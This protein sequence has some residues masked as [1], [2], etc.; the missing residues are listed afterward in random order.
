VYSV[1]T[2]AIGGYMYA[3]AAQGTS[4]RYYNLGSAANTAPVTAASTTGTVGSLSDMRDVQ[5]VGTYAYVAD[6]AAGL[7][8]F[9]ISASNTAGA[10]TT[11]GALG[12]AAMTGGVA[13]SVKVLGIRRLWATA[14]PACNWSMFRCRPAPRCSPA[15]RRPA[16]CSSPIWWIK[17][18][19]SPNTRPWSRQRQRRAANLSGRRLQRPACLERQLHGYNRL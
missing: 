19:R 2:A 7:K 17:P 18:A 15:R 13:N 11:S 4:L 9:A 12:T 5:I 6:G 8:V 16:A 14:S 10:L 1:R 3:F